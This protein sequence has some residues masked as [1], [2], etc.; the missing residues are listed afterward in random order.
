MTNILHRKSFSRSWLTGAIAILLLGS[1]GTYFILSQAQQQP[2]QD[3]QVEILPVQSVTALGRLEPQGEVIKLSVANAQDSRVNQLLV[4]EGDWVEAG[5]VIAI[6][7]GLD[8]KQAELTEAQQNVVI[9]QTR[10]AQIATGE[11]K[12]ADIAAQQATINQLEAQLRTE[13][14]ERQAEIV[15][16]QAELRNAEQTYQRYHHLHEEGAVETVVRDERRE[17]FETAQATLSEAKAH[18]ENTVST[19]GERIRHEQALLD[20]LEEVRPV[21]LQA[22]QA[23]LDHAVAQVN[24]IKAELEDYYVRVPVAGQIL[25][26]NTHVGEQVNTS[27]GIVELGRTAQMYA[28]AEVYET[29]VGLVKPG[30]RATV[31]SEHGGFE[32]EIRG[33][34]DHVGM[35]IKKQDV[36]DADPAADKDARVVEVKVR[37]DPDDN[38]K[39]A[40]L[41]NLQV[42]ITIDVER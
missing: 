13:T 39:I 25:K 12:I 31:I 29:D 28:I 2:T 24:R 11:A 18:L 21:D 16:A 6:L 22:A 4:A 40:S 1:M 32:G 36:I 20:K 42:R 19:L 5:E 15:S 9:Y 27:Q 23:E 30:Q 38:D 33:T 10:R 7:Q 34:I 26:I 14:I 41:T 3:V 17:T 8:K 37:I 35:Q